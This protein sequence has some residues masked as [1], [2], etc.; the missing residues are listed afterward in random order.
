MVVYK[1]KA[2]FK[3]EDSFVFELVGKLEGNPTSAKV[4]VTVVVK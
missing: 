2:G 1:P 4:R 3:G